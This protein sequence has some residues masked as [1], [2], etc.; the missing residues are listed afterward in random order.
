MKSL[1]RL[2]HI[3]LVGQAHAGDWVGVADTLETGL[4]LADHVSGDPILVSYL[5][6]MAIEDILLEGLVLGLCT[7]G[8]DPDAAQLEALWEVLQVHHARPLDLV[9]ALEAERAVALRTI[10]QLGAGCP[11]GFLDVTSK[12]PGV[13]VV[14]ASLSPYS[15]V[16]PL[17]RARYE[18][19][20]D[21]ILA[22][23]RAPHGRVATDTSE[24]LIDG[25]GPPRMVAIVTWILAPVLAKLPG[26]RDR[27]LARWR[28]TLAA[29]EALRHHRASGQ[30]PRA[31]EELDL[32][33]A[34]RID[35]CSTDG[36][37]L[38]LRKEED[39]ALLMW[40]VG[41][42]RV[43]DGG[44]TEEEAWEQCRQCDLVV[45]IYPPGTTARTLPTW[46]EAW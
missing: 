22:R 26:K 34:D 2:H 13:D 14:P 43:D 8:A 30:W 36:S 41:E 4:V 11:G 27:I 40:S 29:L 19:V 20:L 15:A 25:E 32:P 6:A 39:G 28:L 9:P 37:L 24:V 38:H 35:P 18:E 1:A 33:A 42:N 5:V 23:A 7:P 12:L 16:Y 10:D 46:D 45:R 21:T 17:D 44:L 3:Q 31:V